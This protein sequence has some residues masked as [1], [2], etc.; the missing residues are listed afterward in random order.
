MERREH[1]TGSL[2]QIRYKDNGVTRKTKTWYLQFYDNGKRVRESS[3][4]EDKREAQKKLTQR[5]A[6]IGTG[7]AVGEVKGVRYEAVRDAWLTYPR[8]NRKLK[9][10]YTKPDGTKT[11]SGLLHLDKFFAG[12]KV[13][14][15]N[16]ASIDRYIQS[17]R[18]AGAQDATIRRNLTILR[19]M[20][21]YA[22]EDRRFALAVVPSFKH[23]MPNDS[24]PRNGFVDA[25]DFAKIVGQLPKNCRPLAIFQFR[26]GCRTGAALKIVWENVSND[27][28]EIELPAEI[29]KTGEPLTLPL[30]GDGLKDVAEYLRKQKRRPG[31]CIFEIGEDG[32]KSGGREAYRYH[33]NRA[34]DKLGF[35]TYQ[36][37]TRRYTG[38]RPHDLRRSAIKNLIRSGVPRHVAMNISGH[39][40]ESVFNRYHIVETAEI[41]EAL[42]RAGKHDA[43]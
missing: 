34:C 20:L 41:S 15:I 6:A 13:A 24:K 7:R 29:T 28:S 30:V 19:A 1:G 31:R 32:A 5:L 36:R 3:R 25:T 9:T 2:L 4:T 38:L 10:A 37:K 23:R 14:D 39:K 33:W 21:N 40:T 22:H 17:R 43:L 16:E 18:D 35:G 42:I 8:K 12:W 27:C 26:T 11:A